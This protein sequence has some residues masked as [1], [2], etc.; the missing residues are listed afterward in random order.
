MADRFDGVVDGSGER[1]VS[2]G[3]VGPA[4]VGGQ[5]GGQGAGGELH[6]AVLADGDESGPFGLGEF[7]F[8]VGAAGPAEQGGGG[9]GG[10]RGEQQ[11]GVG[12]GGCL[13]EQSTG[14]LAGL[15]GDGQG[16]GVVDAFAG[17]GER[18]AQ[19]QGQAGVAAAGL[20]DP[21]GE[22]GG[23]PV[24]YEEFGEVVGAERGHP[25][26]GGAGAAEGFGDGGA[27]LD[28][29]GDEYPDPRRGQAQGE[30]QQVGGLG[31]EP[32]GVVDDEQDGVGGGEGPQD[33]DDGE[34]QGD[35][36]AA[37]ARRVGFAAQPGDG[38]ALGSGQAFQR[39]PGY[40]GEQGGGGRLGYPAVGGLRGEPQD[41]LAAGR[42]GVGQ[43]RGHGGL[44][45]PA[46]R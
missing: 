1:G 5:G 34:A 16:V 19:G 10:E 21:A 8:G 3:A 9:A 17:F 38:G 29:F 30:A 41:A 36:V 23:Q 39:V 22:A 40:G 37:G 26:A 45:G 35:V 33:R 14:D 44:A 24:P 6:R 31:V 25:Q 11:R 7:G 20:V 15:S 27:A 4:G 28:A 2:G 12:A 32:L 43:L 18:A 46:G 13:G 42:G